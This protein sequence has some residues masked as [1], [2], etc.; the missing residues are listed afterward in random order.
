M[1]VVWGLI[2]LLLVWV[3]PALF[4][5][6]RLG[7]DERFELTKG[8][9]WARGVS[10]Y[11]PLWNDQPPLLTVL[12]GLCFKVFGPSIAMARTLALGFGLAL[13]VAVTKV[14][15]HRS[16][17]LAAALAVFSLLSAPGVL[18]LTVSVMLEVPAMG[19]ALWA[20]WPILRWQ[21][22][23]ATPHP[24]NGPIAGSASEDAN[25]QPYRRA[26]RPS[27]LRSARWLWLVLSGAILAMALQIKLTAAL[28]AP[29]LAME[30]LRG[31][32]TDDR[33]PRLRE[34]LCGIG[35]WAATLISGYALIGA[36]IGQVPA[37]VLWAS[38]FSG[39]VRSAADNS[40]VLPYWP[41]LWTDYG[42]VLCGAGLGLL[43]L[44]WQRRWHTLRFPAVWLLTVALA[45][46]VHRPFWSIYNLHFAVPLAWLAGCG[47][48][49]LFRLAGANLAQRTVT[50]RRIGFLSLAGGSVLLAALI[51]YGG[52]RLGCEAVRIRAL[53]RVADSEWV[54]RMRQFARDT[55]W[56]Y[57]RETIY[58]FHAGLL[59]VPELA[60]LP[61]KRFW[62]GQITEEQIWVVVMRYEPEQLLLADHELRSGAWPFVERRYK[63]VYRDGGLTLYI[64]K[65][66]LLDHPPGANRVR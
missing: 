63:S 41:G 50:A 37:E 47:I 52:E 42:E 22:A 65:K 64:S 1:V 66:L 3:G 36:L 61:V 59:V 14:V 46:A 26:C 10:L 18:L 24:G 29:A 33:A 9:L 35:L 32:P 6:V 45:H 11:H 13:L 60:V 51:T 15:S 21:Q 43:V 54:A 8:L 40:K 49:E 44:G 48:A 56:V 55:Q 53:P 34:R 5:A 20:L 7:L 58:P 38:H 16:G 39:A 4:N 57:T 25:A 12:L 31:R 2:A 30:L 17:R 28:A 62:S 23:S 27:A 19:T